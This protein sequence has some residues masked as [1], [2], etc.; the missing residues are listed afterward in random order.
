VLL[1]GGASAML[2]V[3]APGITL[4]DKRTTTARLLAT[5][6]D[7]TSL[8]MVRKHLS[9]IK[10][11]RLAAATRARTLA[12]LLSDVVGNDPSVIGSGPTVADATTFEDALRVLDRFG[13][14]GS[15]PVTVVQRLEHGAAGRVPDT[16][17]PG[18]ADLMRAT[19]EVIGSALDAV[20]AAAAM[21][22]R[23]GYQVVLSDW[24]VT[25][26]ARN[27][28]HT[29]AEW[30]TDQLSRHDGRVCLLSSGET[31]VTV[32][33][34]GIGGRNQ[35]FALALAMAWEDHGRPTVAVSFGTDGVDG[36]T[37]A[38]GARVSRDTIARARARGL[39]A[40]LA[41]QAND[42]WSFFNAL[43]GLMRT[44]PTGTNVGDVQIVLAAGS[45]SQ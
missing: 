32:R 33:G 31:T 14:R 6:A 38:A 12:W 18:A 24:P 25:G 43:G 1:S 22:R 28:A 34:K 45:E 27:A 8:N 16:P 3:P 19:T 15:Y 30:L 36:P 17:K 23:L 7:I 35:E 37:D 42:S 41:L 29:H 44:G 11:G 40:S 5:G 2:A 10:G 13:G 21:A 20:N 39:D 26:E 4:D 9:E